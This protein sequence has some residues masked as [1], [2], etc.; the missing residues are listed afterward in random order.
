METFDPT[1]EPRVETNLPATPTPAPNVEPPPPPA[2]EPSDEP[3]DP[4]AV[5]L[6]NEDDAQYLPEDD[7]RRKE[8]EQRRGKPF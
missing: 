7:P 1:R 2:P 4:H 5:P 8:V 3:S 6:E